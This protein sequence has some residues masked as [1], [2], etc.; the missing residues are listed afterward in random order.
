MAVYVVE[1]SCHGGWISCQYVQLPW[2][3]SARQQWR[4]PYHVASVAGAM[5]SL[6]NQ[7]LEMMLQMVTL[8]R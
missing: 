5:P 7:W 8:K 4:C 1:F 3:M 6:F 2:P